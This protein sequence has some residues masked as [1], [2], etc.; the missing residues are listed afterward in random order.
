MATPNSGG[1]NSVSGRMN[2]AEED[3]YEKCGD[4]HFV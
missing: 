3:R 1:V 4:G 2:E